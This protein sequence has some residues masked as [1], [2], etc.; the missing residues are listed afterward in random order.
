MESSAGGFRC[1]MKAA[2]DPDIVPQEEVYI[3]VQQG[4]LEDNKIKKKEGTI[5]VTTHRILWF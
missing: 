3:K 5:M 1:K 4:T 2:N